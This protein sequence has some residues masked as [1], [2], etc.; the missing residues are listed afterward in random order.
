[1]AFGLS[2]R[3]KNEEEEIYHHSCFLKRGSD[4][5]VRLISEISA[6]HSFMNQV[7]KNSSV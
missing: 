4:S 5:K 3:M 7:N 2:D 1:M 6:N